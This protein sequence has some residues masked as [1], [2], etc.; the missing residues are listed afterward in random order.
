MHVGKSLETI[1]NVD[2]MASKFGSALRKLIAEW[3]CEKVYTRESKIPGCKEGTD[4][5]GSFG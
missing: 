1:F 4:S 5:W 2:R 3:V